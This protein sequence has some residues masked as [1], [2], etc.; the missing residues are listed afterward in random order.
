MRFGMKKIDLISSRHCG[1]ITVA[2]LCEHA[3]A[4]VDEGERVRGG[5][6]N[7]RLRAHI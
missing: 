7:T 6:L 3:L 2:E 4:F 5:I 1:L